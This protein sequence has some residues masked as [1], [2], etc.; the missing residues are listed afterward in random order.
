MEH[1]II[2]LVEAAKALRVPVV[3][4]EQVPS[5]L[6]GTSQRI[7]DAAGITSSQGEVH[8]PPD[9][10]LESKTKF[11]MATPAV[12]RWLKEHNVSRAVLVGAEAHICVEQT[13]RDLAANG[14]S[15]DVV[16][17]GVSSIRRF[18]RS[19]ALA[20]MAAQAAGGI[21]VTSAEAVAFD[22]LGDATH[23]AFKQV[24]ALVKDYAKKANSHALCSL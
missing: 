4:T 22:W 20:R 3:V 18:E 10:L 13:T 24:Q 21:T 8:V 5:K 6:G 19:T 16:A 9:V 14:I 7:L 15:V 2:F 23:P 11:S 17:D 12:G 1:T